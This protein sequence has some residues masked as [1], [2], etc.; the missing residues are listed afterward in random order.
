MRTIF[1]IVVGCWV[2][3]LPSGYHQVE[4]IVFVVLAGELIGSIGTD[5]TNIDVDV[6]VLHSYAIYIYIY[7]LL[8]A[9]CTMAKWS[10]FTECMPTA[11][12]DQNLWRR[13]HEESKSNR[14]TICA[15]SI[16]VLFI[17]NAM[18]LLSLSLS[19]H[20]GLQQIKATISGH[21]DHVFEWGL[22]VRWYFVVVVQSQTEL[23]QT[24]QKV[25]E[26][27]NHGHVSR[28]NCDF[29]GYSNQINQNERFPISY[30]KKNEIRLV[31]FDVLQYNNKDV[32]EKKNCSIVCQAKS[33]H[34]FTTKIAACS[35]SV[36]GPYLHNW[37]N[38]TPPIMHNQWFYACNHA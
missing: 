14:R 26:A 16:V 7:I 33:T 32:S 13:R 23:F 15:H 4:R 21:S 24:Q 27:R 8:S 37:P 36:V 6:W 28:R 9:I 12:F 25:Y 34:I 35:C 3:A 31:S 11:S 2:F 30:E 29:V 17:H 18:P 10:G 5:I 20:I 19:K 22:L 38:K 1:G